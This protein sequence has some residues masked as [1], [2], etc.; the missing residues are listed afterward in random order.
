MHAHEIF[1][2]NELLSPLIT[3]GPPSKRLRV[4]RPLAP[5]AAVN[6]AT[7]VTFLTSS[8][9]KLQCNNPRKCR[10]NPLLWTKSCT[11][12]RAL[13]SLTSL[14]F[15]NSFLKQFIKRKSV[16]SSGRR[17]LYRNGEPIQS[18]SLQSRPLSEAINLPSSQPAS[19]AAFLTLT[20]ARA[21]LL[22]SEMHHRRSS[23]VVL[24][25]Q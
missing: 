14:C 1:R 8:I 13:P 11:L 15:L 19:Y 21:P 6:N 12:K 16:M 2:A 20:I 22:L 18:T 24:R 4:Q 23:S 25:Q 5:F 3:N 7:K 17:M 9:N 10:V